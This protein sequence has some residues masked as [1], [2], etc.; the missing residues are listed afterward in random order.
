MEESVSRCEGSADGVGGELGVEVAAEIVGAAV[1]IPAGGTTGVS[2]REEANDVEFDAPRDISPSE[3]V[4]VEEGT[5]TTPGHASISLGTFSD[6]ETTP[7]T[8]S[9]SAIS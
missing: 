7:D 8:S 9:L 4:Q 6:P 3:G 2:R 1:E 5:S